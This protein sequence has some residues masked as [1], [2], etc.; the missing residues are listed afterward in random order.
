LRLPSVSTSTRSCP[1]TNVFTRYGR[2]FH[3]L[4]VPHRLFQRHGISRL[5]LR[6]DGKSPAKKKFKHYPI[7]YLPG[8][9]ACTYLWLST[10]A[11]KVAFAQVQPRATKRLAALPYQVHTVLTDNGT[12]FGNSPHQPYAGHHIFGCVCDEHSTTSP[13]W[14]SREP[15]VRSSAHSIS[16]LLLQLL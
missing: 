16:I 12:P 5:P 13:S 6:K 3:A 9:V 1:W 2:R 7:G 11:S 14:P 8:K 10:S 4:P 15:T